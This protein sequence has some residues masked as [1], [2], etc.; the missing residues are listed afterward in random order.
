MSN[1][2]DKFFPVMEHMTVKGVREY[3]E[4]KQ[5]IILPVGVTEQHGYHLPLCTDALIAGRIAR[6]AGE[7]LGMLVGTTI[8]QSFSGGGLP[9][10]INISPAVMSLVISD[11]LMS[12]VAQGFRNFYL[13]LGHG[14][15]E[16]SRALNDAVK[17]LLR[18]NPAFK[19]VLLAI[20][21][22]WTMSSPGTGW[23]KALTKESPDWHAGWLETSIVMTL[24]PELVRMD[25]MELDKEPYF[26]QQIAHPDNYQ[27][28]EKIVN[29]PL[30]VPRMTQRSEIKV[31]VMGHPEKADAKMGKEIVEDIVKNL[32]ARISKIE[33]GADG[34]YKEVEFKPEPLIF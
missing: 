5:S 24:A 31:G 13:F 15:S 9:G 22:V 27:H 12:L 30:V 3:L 10:T 25:E 2:R 17:M 11:T 26:S 8:L 1:Q 28:A 19:N 4:R 33:A 16:N 18:N 7:K 34:V 23:N 14:G 20:I 29:D 21:P 6:M 32:T